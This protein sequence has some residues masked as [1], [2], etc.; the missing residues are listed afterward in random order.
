MNKRQMKKAAKKQVSALSDLV[1][2]EPPKLTWKQRRA[3][4][5]KARKR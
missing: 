1:I 3:V 4:A 2:A 5:R